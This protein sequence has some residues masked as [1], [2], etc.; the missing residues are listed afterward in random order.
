MN[1]LMAKL[2]VCA[3]KARHV[4]IASLV[5]FFSYS[6]ALVWSLSAMMI[7]YHIIKYL[8]HLGVFPKAVAKIKPAWCSTRKK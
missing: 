5:S 8:H 3:V 2:A 1:V 4:W 7:R 6:C